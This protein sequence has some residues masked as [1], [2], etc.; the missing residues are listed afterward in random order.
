MCMRCDAMRAKRT[1]ALPDALATC[2]SNFTLPNLT[3]CPDQDKKS[4]CYPEWTA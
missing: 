2:S 3:L 4:K 1:G